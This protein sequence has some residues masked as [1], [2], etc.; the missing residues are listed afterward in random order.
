MS[1]KRILCAVD[2]SADSLEAFRIA[3]EM[4]R[5]PAAS[6]HLFHVIESQPVMP[7]DVEIRIIEEANA[8]MEKLVASAQSSPDGLALTTEV[9]SGLA[10]VEIIERAR[11]WR[12][13]LIVLGSTGVTSLEEIIIGGTA[14]RVM[15]EAPCSVLIVR[16]DQKHDRAPVRN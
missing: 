16:P 10:S 9:T 11:E 1:F 7:A 13:E 2:F 15:K 4:A 5:Q 14:E 12:A 6:L 8:A 3:A